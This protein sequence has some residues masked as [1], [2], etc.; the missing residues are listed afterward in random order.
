MICTVRGTNAY[1]YTCAT[2]WKIDNPDIIKRS[3]A[4]L[5]APQNPSYNRGSAALWYQ[6]PTE[7]GKTTIIP[8]CSS[9]HVPHNSDCAQEAMSDAAGRHDPT[10]HSILWSFRGNREHNHNN[11]V[12]TSHKI[13]R[14][15]AALFSSASETSSVHG[16]RNSAGANTEGG[17]F[18]FLTEGA[19]YCTFTKIPHLYRTFRLSADSTRRCDFVFDFCVQGPT[20]KGKP[21]WLVALVFTLLIWRQT[22]ERERVH[23]VKGVFY[24]TNVVSSRGL[25][26]SLWMS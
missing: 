21:P 4:C 8:H 10:G 9:W 14:R 6:T 13:C 3:H 18:F 24:T 12:H 11:I 5:L 25:L 15:R 2:C 17:L 16:G 1:T 19:T 23:R 20:W 26:R 22:T 7:E